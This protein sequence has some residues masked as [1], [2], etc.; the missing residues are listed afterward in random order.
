MLPEIVTPEILTRAKSVVEPAMKL[1]VKTL[2]P[3][4]ALPINYHFGW[5]DDGGEIE[6]GGKGV[7]MALAVLSAE[8]VGADAMSAIPGASAVELVHN[9]SLIHDDV[10]D[11]DIERRHR[12]TVW[13]AFG[14]EDALLAGDALLA[15]AFQVLLESDSVKNKNTN[16]NN[17]AAV[18][19]ARATSAMI[20]GQRLDTKIDQAPSVE[21][22]E[23]MESQKTGVLLSCSA[24][25]GAILADAEEKEIETLRVYGMEFGMAFQAVDDLLG[26]W[27]NPEITGKPAGN[28]IQENKRSLPIVIALEAAEANLKLKKKLTEALAKKDKGA[29]DIAL[30]TDIL[31]NLGAREATKAKANQH[32]ELAIATIDEKNPAGKEFKE[33]AEFATN[34]DF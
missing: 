14:L 12:A 18:E 1:A 20:A 24:A 19:L 34:R 25:I 31:E 7:R 32:L 4:L 17:L 29:E 26:I 9:F 23:F 8:Y 5:T 2:T 30:I 27:G 10:I 6:G 13:K 11:K 33:L 28:D 16:K 21:A 15:L 3:N 22:C